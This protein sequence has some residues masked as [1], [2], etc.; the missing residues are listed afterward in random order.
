[1]LHATLALFVVAF[2]LSIAAIYWAILN[3]RRYKLN[4]LIS[5]ELTKIIENTTERIEKTKKS[6][7][8]PGIHNVSGM[9]QGDIFCLLYTSDAADDLL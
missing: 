9:P 3:Y 8:E 7:A 2:A 4:L 1:M 5:N 6:T